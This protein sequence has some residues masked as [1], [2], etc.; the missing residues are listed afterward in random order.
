MIEEITVQICKYSFTFKCIMK[1]LDIHV[2]SALIKQARVIAQ[3]LLLQSFIHLSLTTR[4]LTDLS[5]VFWLDPRFCQKRTLFANPCYHIY[6]A[7]SAFALFNLLSIFQT[8]NASSRLYFRIESGNL[9]SNLFLITSF[10]LFIK[11]NLGFPHV[12]I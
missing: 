9:F 12:K 1:C 6:K 3:N 10:C 7:S 11:R 5:F 4:K 8:F 2:L